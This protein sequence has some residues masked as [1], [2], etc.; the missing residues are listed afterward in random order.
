MNQLAFD[1]QRFADSKNPTA[2]DTIKLI[3]GIVSS[4]SLKPLMQEL[5]DELEGVKSTANPILKFI[6]SFLYEEAD[7][8]DIEHK[9]KKTRVSSYAT[10]I[11]STVEIADDALTVVLELGNRNKDTSK[12]ASSVSSI[13]QNVSDM[14]SAIADLNR[15]KTSYS[16]S[17]GL[18]S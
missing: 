6:G 2:F 4:L 16:K 12:I 1:L 14:S 5:K 17:F 11:T 10:I 9:D 13:A 8:L 3:G 7:E 15:L 18:S